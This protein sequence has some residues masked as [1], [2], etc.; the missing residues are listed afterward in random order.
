MHVH[1]GSWIQMHSPY[2]YMCNAPLH[3]TH[4]YLYYCSLDLKLVPS[5][6]ERKEE[7]ML[8]YTA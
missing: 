2:M 6:R 7:K 1:T 3:F 8:I 5:I 4:L